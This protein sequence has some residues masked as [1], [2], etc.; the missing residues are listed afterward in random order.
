M[1]LQKIISGGDMTRILNFCGY[2]HAEF[3]NFIKKSRSFVSRNLGEK[4]TVPLK[5]VDELI[6]F[7]GQENYALATSQIELEDRKLKIINEQQDQISILQ[8]ENRDLRSAV[9]FYHNAYLDIKNQYDELI[10]L[11]EEKL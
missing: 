5:Y 9:E 7:V 10:A 8:N 4:Q 6:R 2:N 11:Q 1:E 3:S